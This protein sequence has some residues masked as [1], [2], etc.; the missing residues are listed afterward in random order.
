LG[1]GEVPCGGKARD[2]TTEGTE[3]TEKKKEGGAE[4]DIDVEASI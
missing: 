2:F 3:S 1:A 4:V